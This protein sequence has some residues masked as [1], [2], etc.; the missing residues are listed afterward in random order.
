MGLA[1]V[2]GVMERHDGRVEVLSELGKGTTI[3][4]YLPLPTKAT[5]SADDAAELEAP[6]PMRILCIDDEPL[7]R[8]LMKGLLESDG[9][10]VQV[11]DSGQSGIDAFRAARNHRP[12]DVIIT[13]LGMPFLDGRQVA[14][15]LKTESPGTPVLMLTGWG[16]FMKADG[17]LPAH[18]DGV[19]SK[20]PRS[21]ELR[22]T[23]AR[24]ARR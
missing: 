15:I 13:D 4:L 24:L 3:R 1:M 16:A 21:K 2:Y 5:T 17:D 18:V 7:L 22:E 14:R 23:L 20:P 11:A 9:H 10:T 19:L 6:P 8:E 12:F